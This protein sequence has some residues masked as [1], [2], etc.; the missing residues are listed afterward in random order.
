MV[1]NKRLATPGRIRLIDHLAS[2]RDIKTA[3]AQIQ[4]TTVT[5]NQVTPE[6]PRMCAFRNESTVVSENKRSARGNRNRSYN[7]GI[8]STDLED[9]FQTSRPSDARTRS[10]FMSANPPR[11]SIRTSRSWFGGS[12]SLLSP[13]GLI[14]NA[15]KSIVACRSSTNQSWRASLGP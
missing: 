15:L 13:R 4:R 12:P 5:V 3:I 6:R 7:L 10:R 2:V 8:C 14:L 11:H 9:T 1:D